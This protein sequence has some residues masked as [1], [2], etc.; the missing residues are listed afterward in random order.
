M[1]RNHK[2]LDT[3]LLSNIDALVNRMYA[4]KALNVELTQARKIAK[5]PAEKLKNKTKKERVKANLI[6]S[7]Y[8]LLKAEDNL[9]ELQQSKLT[10]RFLT[11]VVRTQETF[12]LGRG[13]FRS[14]RLVTVSLFL[15]GAQ[16]FLAPLQSFAQ[17]SLRTDGTMLVE[18]KAF[19]P[20]GYYSQWNYTN[21]QRMYQ[22]RTL[23]AGGFNTYYGEANNTSLSD[24]GLFLDEAYRQKV[25]VVT[26]H[27]GVLGSTT[28]MDLVNY[29][30]E[31]P[32]VL[33]WNIADDANNVDAATV[34]DYHK[35]VKAADPNHISYISGYDKDGIE[36]FMNATDF[37][38][39]QSYPLP[40]GCCNWHDSTPYPAPYLASTFWYMKWTIDKGV[41][42]NRTVIGNLQTFKWDNG[43]WPTGKEVDNMSY[44]AIVAGVKGIAYYTFEDGSSTIATTRPDVWN[45]TKN[46]ASELKLLAPI[47][48]NGQRTTTVEDAQ[49][50]VY[51]AQWKYNGSVYVIVVNTSNSTKQVSVELPTGTDGTIQSVFASRPSSMKLSNNT[52]LGDIDPL[53]VH[54]YVLGRNTL[55]PFQAEAE[56]LPVEGV[57]DTYKNILDE[58]FS[59]G[60]ATRFEAN[61]VQ[62]YITYSI[63]VPE[64]RKYNVRVGVKK[65]LTRGKFQFSVNGASYGTFQDLYASSEQFVELDVADITFSSSGKKS[66]KFTVVGKNPQSPEYRL[67]FDYIKLIPR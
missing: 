10:A 21:A 5:Q 9:N 11:N 39:M 4:V 67:D 19:F 8:V 60:A 27:F 43:R 35:R 58:K 12:S 1:S 46:V 45:A 20:I 53:D 54:V 7:K 59:E 55:P 13:I 14:A 6:Q 17:S 15:A 31:K 26:K 29:F 63:N 40:Q 2:G 37:V 18:G 57:S 42:F 41:P 51:S 65:Y 36:N 33:G 22:I 62:D 24:Y 52:L 16:F 32:A 44:Q 64:A 25:M 61:A 38:G 30:K 34:L 47:L 49:K 23:G 50:A 28:N 48:L 56:K 66:F 3:G